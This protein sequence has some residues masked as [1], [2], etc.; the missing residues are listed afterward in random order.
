[1]VKKNVKTII[2]VI[3]HPPFTLVTYATRQGEK[4]QRF[5]YQVQLNLPSC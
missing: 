1:M 5:L 3:D 4:K 2:S